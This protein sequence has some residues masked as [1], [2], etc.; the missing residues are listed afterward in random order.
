MKEYERNRPASRIRLPAPR[1]PTP[2]ELERRREVVDRI[3]ELRR[4]MGPIG[5]PVDELIRQVREE[6]ERDG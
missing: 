6:D 3:L 4:A 1:R 5:I 2:R